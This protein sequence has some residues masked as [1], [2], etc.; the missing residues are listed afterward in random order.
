VRHI[1]EADAMVCYAALVMVLAVLSISAKLM[2]VTNARRTSI[3]AE[4][5]ITPISDSTSR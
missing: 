2:R 5:A 1:E 3:G 4:E